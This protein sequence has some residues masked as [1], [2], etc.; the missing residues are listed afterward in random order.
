MV[1]PKTYF[2]FAVV[3]DNGI[4][5]QECTVR[6]LLCNVGDVSDEPLEC[7]L[8]EG[9]G[10]Y[11]YNDMRDF[12]VPNC[13]STRRHRR[14]LAMYNDPQHGVQVRRDIEI[15]RQALITQFPWFYRDDGD[16]D[17]QDVNGYADATNTADAGEA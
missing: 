5:K 13:I 12:Q 16:A 3:D 11:R 4:D 7:R 10:P 1:L 15:R 6:C 9:N 2:C 17:V 8:V 14:A